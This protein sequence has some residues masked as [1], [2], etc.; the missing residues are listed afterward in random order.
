MNPN[1]VYDAVSD[2]KQL[3]HKKNNSLEFSSNS[4]FMT[5]NFVQGTKNHRKS[6]FFFN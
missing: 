5:Q 3:N 4:L 6:L 1:A 2:F